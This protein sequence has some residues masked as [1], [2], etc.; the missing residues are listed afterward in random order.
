MSEEARK[1]ADIINEAKQKDNWITPSVL[2]AKAKKCVCDP[3]PYDYYDAPSYGVVCDASGYIK[4][5]EDCGSS[6]GGNIH[7]GAP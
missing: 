4:E 1:L 2:G 7:P 3:G 5:C 6:P